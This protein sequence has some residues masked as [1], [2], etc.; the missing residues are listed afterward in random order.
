MVIADSYFKEGESQRNFNITVSQNRWMSV[1][2]FIDLIQ[3]KNTQE[4]SDI[5]EK[6]LFFND[7]DFNLLDTHT[8]YG[9]IRMQTM[10]SGMVNVAGIDHAPSVLT[11]GETQVRKVPA[12]QY[13]V[14][15]S[16]RNGKRETRTAN[17]G[18]KGVS[19]V[20]F[21]YTP[22]LLEGDFSK[23]PAFGV[24]ISELNPANYKKTDT[25]VL[26]AM[27][28]PPWQIAFI[29]GENH[30]KNAKY[31]EAIGEYSKSIILKNDYAFS[32]ASRGSAYR[33]TGDTARAIEDYTRALRLKPDYAEIYNYRGFLYGQRGELTSAVSDYTQAINHKSNYTDAIFNRAGIY[34][35]QQNWDRAIDD[36]SRLLKLEPGNVTAYTERSRAYREKGEIEK[37]DADLEKAKSLK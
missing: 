5:R 24:K 35:K 19:W 37:A 7:E 36:Y 25:A 32:Y 13:L 28:M 17:V 3:G 8:G 22:E 18:Y 29:A 20:T 30:Y 9:E 26:R 11:F 4:N 34:V 21:N 12:G 31:R 23:L 14:T 2:D 15:M 33:K 10:F 27:E 1:L 16:Y 6:L